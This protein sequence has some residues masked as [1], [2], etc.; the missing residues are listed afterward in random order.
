MRL[1]MLE[2]AIAVI[3]ELWTGEQSSHY[4]AHYTVENARIYTLP[5]QPPPIFVSASGR[6]RSSSRRGSATAS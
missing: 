2:E 3:R 1:E 6:R 4:G 5:G